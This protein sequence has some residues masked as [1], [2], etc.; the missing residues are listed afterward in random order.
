MRRIGFLGATNATAYA[1]RI[2]ALRAG[3]RDLGYVEG[4][5]LE[6]VFRWADGRYERLAAL[7]AELVA[8]KVDV[9]VTHA[10]PPTL[11]AKKA[12]ATIPI[13]M[14]NVGDAQSTGIV[15]NLARPEG[16]ITG[17][18]FFAPELNLK[19]LE[20]L[21]STLPQAQ[22]I[23]VLANLENPGNA[24]TVREMEAPATGLGLALERFDVRDAVALEAAFTAMAARRPHALAVLED[25]ALIG[26]LKP[27]AE[28][29]LRH[30]LPSIG[31]V[32]FAAAG[33]MI[34]YGPDFLDL[35]RRAAGTVDRILKGAR[36]GD[37]PVQRPTKFLLVLNLATARSLGVTIPESVRLRAN[38]LVG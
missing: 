1:Q 21:K 20:L 35:Y 12:T 31:F 19:R 4:V 30:G 29:A 9:I 38:E 5:T 24:R 37:I 34:G 11:A 7:A 14:T 33:G 18:T 28:G 26:L 6:I 16:N 23:A 25:A 32:E 27:I 8:L 17:D 2:E 36:P 13:V 3:F 22:R 10:I 15:A